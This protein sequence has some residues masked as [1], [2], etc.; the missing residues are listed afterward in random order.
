MEML[1][2]QKSGWS[3]VFVVENVE[4][5]VS[6]DGIVTSPCLE[7]VFRP[8]QGCSSQQIQGKNLLEG[9]RM[10]GIAPSFMPCHCL[11]FSCGLLEMCSLF[12][13]LETELLCRWYHLYRRNHSQKSLLSRDPWLW[14][15]AAMTHP[16]LLA[17]R[18]GLAKKRIPLPKEVVC[19][20]IYK[21]WAFFFLVF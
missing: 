8:W 16:W 17:N 10:E 15:G 18:V 4:V 2:C 7:S 3:R 12:W 5:V 13:V 20:L 21:L 11:P 14:R 9:H 6:P 1:F 19:S